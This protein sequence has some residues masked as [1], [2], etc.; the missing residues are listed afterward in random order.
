MLID[1]LS[2]SVDEVHED[3]DNVWCVGL[4]KE[5][6]RVIIYT[7]ADERCNGPITGF[8]PLSPPITPTI[9]HHF[10]HSRPDIEKQIVNL[11]PQ[12]G[13]AF[14]IP[15]EKVRPLNC[16]SDIILTRLIVDTD[17][18]TKLTDENKE[19]YTHLCTILYQDIARGMKRRLDCACALRIKTI[20]GSDEK[21]TFKP[22]DIVTV[23]GVGYP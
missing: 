12:E 5:Y 11:L 3:D 20:H 15:C 21:L 17:F 4:L 10:I 2:H 13:G 18:V 8:C 22:V 7:F 23:T 1:T 9:P 6:D 14:S 16:L 19:L